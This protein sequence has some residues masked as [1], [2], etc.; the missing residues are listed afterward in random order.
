MASLSQILGFPKVEI[1]PGAA[2]SPQ[3]AIR[4]L[5]TALAKHGRLDAAAVDPVA[6]AVDAREAVATTAIGKGVAIPH[7]SNSDHV[8]KLIGIIGK[9]AVPISWPGAGDSKPV[10]EVYLLVSP[11]NEPGQHLR[12]LDTIVRWFGDG[13]GLS[14]PAS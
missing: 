11:R 12:A 6:E 14:E 1:P 8:K 9:S 2:A 10:C 3:T 5:V 4:F 13:P 7:D